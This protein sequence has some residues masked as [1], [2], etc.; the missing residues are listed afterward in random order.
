MTT[1]FGEITTAEQGLC[2]T[3]NN[4]LGLL[5]QGAA[6]LKNLTGL[7]TMHRLAVKCGAGSSEIPELL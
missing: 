4:S 7:C 5:R 1:F 6:F 3:Q 2:S